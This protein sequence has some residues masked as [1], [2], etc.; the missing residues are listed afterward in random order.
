[1]SRTSALRAISA[2]GLR[3]FLILGYAL[4]AWTNA[5]ALSDPARPQSDR[6]DSS[7]SLRAAPSNQLSLEML[8]QMAT[9]QVRTDAKFLGKTRFTVDTQTHTFFLD[10]TPTPAQFVLSEKDPYAVPLEALIRNESLRRD[11]ASAIP[12]DTVWKA[13]VEAIQ[14]AVQGCIELVNGAA[15]KDEADTQQKCS[16]LVD[17][18]FNRLALSVQSYAAAHRLTESSIRTRGI[19][20]PVVIKVIPPGARVRVMTYLEYKKCQAL[21][22]AESKYQWIDLL[23]SRN[24][25]IGMY[26][27]RIEWPAK[28][29]GPEEGN[30]NI[31]EPK[32]IDFT[33]PAGK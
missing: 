10:L 12:D 18:Q 20:Y 13:Q 25:M 26:R 5:N 16:K 21:G 32:E 3:Y 27:Y 23:A 30:L 22:T 29:N 4:V 19:G 2:D 31:D 28:L 17:Q 33:P 15:A 8:L 6:Q 9:E 1:M 11:F 7:S 14:A 24:T